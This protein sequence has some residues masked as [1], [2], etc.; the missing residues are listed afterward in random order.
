MLS[1]LVPAYKPGGY[2]KYYQLENKRIPIMTS[3]TFDDPHALTRGDMMRL[4]FAAKWGE[5]HTLPYS[6]GFL[7]NF[8]AENC[9]DRY[10]EADGQTNDMHTRYFFAD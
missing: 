8:E 7:A 1:P 4:G 10:W 5:S 9:Y 3:L 6:A 2:I